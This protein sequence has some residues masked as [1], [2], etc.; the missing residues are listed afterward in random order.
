ME[1]YTFHANLGDTVGLQLSTVATTPTGQGVTLY[2]YRPDAGVITNALAPY[3]TTHTTS[4]LLTTLTGLPVAGT[5]TVIAVPDYG[6]P[7][8]GQLTYA[9]DT[10]GAAPVYGT[11]TLPTTGVAQ[12]ESTTT[13]SMTM[14]FNANSGDNMEF[15]LNNISHEIQVAIY[16]P[17]GSVV[18]SYLCYASAPLSCTQSLWNLTA[19]TY[20]VTITV[21]SGTSATFNAIVEKDLMGGALTANTPA[22]INLAAGQA[23]RMTFAGTAGSTVAL[24]L[25]SVVTSPTNQNVYVSIY[26]PD[27]G[28]ITSSNVY[29]S[30]SSA[31]ANVL[32]LPNLPVSGTYTVIVTTGG[33]VPATAQLTLTSGA[34]GVIVKNGAHAECRHH[35]VSPVRLCH[36]HC[37]QW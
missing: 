34:T 24:S 15:T 16:T 21:I 31:T 35:C 17:S 30:F 29:T 36:L 26:R 10:A 22:S 13:G 4:S 11:P 7:A 19:G 27:T 37:E 25:S 32:N 28:L 5:Y 18:T 8:T 14:S 2:V 9:T 12:A 3:S 6:L 23:T 1:R 20:S 33:G